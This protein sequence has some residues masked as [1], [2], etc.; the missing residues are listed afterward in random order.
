MLTELAMEAVLDTY[1]KN[2]NSVPTDLRHSPRHDRRDEIYQAQGMVMV[3]LGI[4]LEQA[5]A[6]MRGHAFAAGQELAEPP[7]SRSYGSSGRPGARAD[8]GELIRTISKPQTT[9]PG[10]DR[11]AARQAKSGDFGTFRCIPPLLW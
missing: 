6:R 10:G 8:G 1:A 2:G 7:T 4:T 9:G 3:R 11:S 5:L